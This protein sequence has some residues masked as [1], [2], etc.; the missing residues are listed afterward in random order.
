MAD[1]TTSWHGAVNGSWIEAGNWTN[2]APNTDASNDTLVFLAGAAHPPSADLDRSGDGGG[3][4]LRP[5]LVYVESGVLYNI[6]SPGNSLVMRAIKVIHKGDG[7][8]FYRSSGAGGTTDEIIIN[9]P[10]AILAAD[11]D[12]EFGSIGVNWL[13]VSQGHVVISDRMNITQLV[14]TQLR[15]L[16]APTVLVNESVSSLERVVING[17]R[18]TCKA[19]ISIFIIVTGGHVILTNTQTLPFL[20]VLGGT[21]VY[22]V[23]DG[24]GAITTLNAIGGKTNLIAE[25]A[26]P[27][28]IT[29]LCKFPGAVVLKDA[30]GDIVSIVNEYGFK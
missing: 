29:N 1:K 4:G 24:G 22:N 10:N 16:P 23:T 26:N 13:I 25:R 5:H 6:G 7:T 15:G 27:L 28:A 30:D 21:V 12:A 18:L 14:M 9:S 11:I 8:L 3:F 19:P 17:G 20:Q 2:G